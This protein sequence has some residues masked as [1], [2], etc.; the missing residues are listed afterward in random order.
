MDYTDLEKKRLEE[1]IKANKAGDTSESNVNYDYIDRHKSNASMIRETYGDNQRGQ[2]NQQPFMYEVTVTRNY[3]YNEDAIDRR[4]R[5]MQEIYE[6]R[7]LNE[8]TVNTT[9]ENKHMTLNEPSYYLSNDYYRELGKSLVNNI[10]NRPTT[11]TN[12]NINFN[13]SVCISERIPSQV[14]DYTDEEVRKMGLN[15]KSWPSY[16]DMINYQE[17]VKLEY[18]RESEEQFKNCI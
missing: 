17:T 4:D 16:I 11:F 1:W 8:V 5:K 10:S 18:I 2:K 12:E 7:R 9:L 6:K 15:Y 14:T 13:A 3:D